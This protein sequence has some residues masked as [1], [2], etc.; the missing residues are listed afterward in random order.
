MLLVEN[1]TYNIFNFVRLDGGGM[2]TCMMAILL[3]AGFA[4]LTTGAILKYGFVQS[5]PFQDVRWR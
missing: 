5:I 4:V 2:S 1:R 3:T